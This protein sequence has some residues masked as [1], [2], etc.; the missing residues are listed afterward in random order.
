MS[1]IKWKRVNLRHLNKW[2]F[3]NYGIRIFF[4]KKI[5]KY[6][7]SH[8]TAGKASHSCAGWVSSLL[9]SWQWHR[10]MAQQLAYCSLSL[11]GSPD[12]S[13]PA[14]WDTSVLAQCYRRNMECK[15]QSC[16]CGWNK[17]SKL[18]ACC[19]CF[20]CWFLF[21]L[22]IGLTSF[23]ASSLTAETSLQL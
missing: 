19:C 3:K 21:L 10:A 14:W 6:C 1:H 18:L 8:R 16:P 12:K 13:K 2:I 22:Y 23:R 7:L 15:E 17:L 9:R 5:T 4:K 20:V 11:V